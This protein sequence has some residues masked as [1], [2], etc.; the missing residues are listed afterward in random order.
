MSYQPKKGDLVRVIGSG[1]TGR[2]FA[3]VDGCRVVVDEPDRRQTY[4][5]VNVR[6]IDVGRAPVA[7]G[8]VRD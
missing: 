3:V 8:R 6:P 2:V 4:N 5:V 7:S 1:V